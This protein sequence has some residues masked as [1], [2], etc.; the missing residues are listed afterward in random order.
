VLARRLVVPRERQTR[1]RVRRKTGA[2][3]ELRFHAR[4]V[5][6]TLIMGTLCR[7]H[8]ARGGDKSYGCKRQ[9]DFRDD[10]RVG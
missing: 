2:D 9:K 6:S 4:C 10:K 3:A 7:T 8:G 5:R 1:T